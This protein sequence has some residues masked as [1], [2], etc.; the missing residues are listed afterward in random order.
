MFE[1]NVKHRA[2]DASN[3]GH[4]PPLPPVG[5]SQVL[6]LIIF[7]DSVFAEFGCVTDMGEVSLSGLNYLTLLAIIADICHK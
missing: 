5:G 1:K 6:D 2:N 3:D 7:E 4:R